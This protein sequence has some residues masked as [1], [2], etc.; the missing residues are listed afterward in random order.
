MHLSKVNLSKQS[1]LTPKSAG[2]FQPTNINIA[3]FGM[4]R[5]LGLLHFRSQI[6]AQ[7]VAEQGVN[8][9]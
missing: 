4:G 7:S 2:Y 1:L 6:P 3:E 5:A 9:T 8:D